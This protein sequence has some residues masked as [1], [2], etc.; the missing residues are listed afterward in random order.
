[1]GNDEE[2][3]MVCDTA[4]LQTSDRF[5][6]AQAMSQ[7]SL[8][9]ALAYAAAAASSPNTTR[10]RTHSVVAPSVNRDTSARISA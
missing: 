3:V 2:P 10:S 7:L 6:R 9:S 1:M 4:L 8:R 5:A